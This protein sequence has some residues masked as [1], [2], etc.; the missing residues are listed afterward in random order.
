MLYKFRISIS[1]PF[2]KSR[3]SGEA[4]GF[5]GAFPLEAGSRVQAFHAAND[6]FNKRGFEVTVLATTPET[7]ANPLGFSDQELSRL[8]EIGLEIRTGFNESEVQ[9]ESLEESPSL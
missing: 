3:L 2:D 8:K 9:I 5:S 1:P 6:W 4:I 7:K